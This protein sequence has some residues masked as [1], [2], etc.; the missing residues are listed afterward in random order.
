MELSEKAEWR[1]SLGHKYFNEE[2]RNVQAAVREFRRITVLA[3]SWIRGYMLLAVALE[4][5]DQINDVIAT[6][7]ASMRVAPE[8]DQ[9][10]TSLGRIYI[11]K[12]DYSKAIKIFR[13]ATLINPNNEETNHLLSLGYEKISK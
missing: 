11:L 13:R 3:P 1:L 4:E 5:I 9:P 8:D 2:P 12:H 10:L 7:R 6:Y